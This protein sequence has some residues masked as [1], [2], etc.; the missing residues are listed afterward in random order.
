MVVLPKTTWISLLL[1]P[2]LFPRKAVKRKHNHWKNAKH[3]LHYLIWKLMHISLGVSKLVRKTLISNKHM[4]ISCSKSYWRI[5]QSCGALF[6]FS[7]GFLPSSSASWFLPLIQIALGIVF[8]VQSSC[9]NHF[10]FEVL[11][12]TETGC[13]YGWFYIPK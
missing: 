10:F 6:V 1:Y 13:R 12:K 11:P 8:N 9:S 2:L 3:E 4:H 5:V 7:S